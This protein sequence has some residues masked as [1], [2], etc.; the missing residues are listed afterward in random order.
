MHIVGVFRI[1]GEAAGLIQADRVV[2]SS[3]RL[4]HNPPGAP[5][6]GSRD[7]VLDQDAADAQAAPALVH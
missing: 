5:L 2:P 1:L 4:D 3:G 7:K 6:P